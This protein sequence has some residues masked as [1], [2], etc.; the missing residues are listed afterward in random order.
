MLKCPLAK[1]HVSPRIAYSPVHLHVSPRYRLLHFR[2]GR[3]RT[4]G[5]RIELSPAGSGHV[6]GQQRYDLDRSC[7]L[8][9]PALAIWGQLEFIP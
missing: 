8:L 5:A 9:V 4:N 3:Y 6:S 2:H 1:N 7:R